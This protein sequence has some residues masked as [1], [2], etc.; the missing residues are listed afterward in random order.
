M[1]EFYS[2]ERAKHSCGPLY[3]GQQQHA[4]EH[5]QDIIY[6]PTTGMA[7]H[8]AA[9]RGD[10]GRED[11]CGDGAGGDGGSSLLGAISEDR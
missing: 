10:G 11:R 2:F 6:R 9:S 1:V 7:R 5:W 8:T 3:V 4:L